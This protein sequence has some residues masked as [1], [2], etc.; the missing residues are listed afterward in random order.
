MGLMPGS[1]KAAIKGKL[2]RTGRFCLEISEALELVFDYEESRRSAT[3]FVADHGICEA[4][5]TPMEEA[6]AQEV[7]SACSYRVHQSTKPIKIF[8]PHSEFALCFHFSL[9]LFTFIPPI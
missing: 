5:S 3:N 8:S 7:S 6:P 2:E 4:G 9:Y 1:V